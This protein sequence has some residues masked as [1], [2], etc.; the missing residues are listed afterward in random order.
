MKFGSVN[1]ENEIHMEIKVQT[2]KE[3]SVYVENYDSSI[4][5]LNSADSCNC[6]ETRIS[7]VLLNTDTYKSKQ[8]NQRDAE[9]KKGRDDMSDSSAS[10][11]E[12]S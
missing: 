3:Y 1:T 2:K 7:S 6:R 11:V 8:V 10:Q 5:H 9:H 12:E 4:S